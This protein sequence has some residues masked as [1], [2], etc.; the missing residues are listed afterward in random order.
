MSGHNDALEVVDFRNL[1]K[2][3]FKLRARIP[4]NLL[5]GGVYSVSPFASVHRQRWLV[6]DV[7]GVSVRIA[8]DVPNSDY[9]YADRRPGQ[10][11]PI[12]EWWES[13]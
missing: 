1:D 9:V 4:G 6:K 13:E 11:S 7:D 5:N 2:K 3:R 12:L 8:F 10:V